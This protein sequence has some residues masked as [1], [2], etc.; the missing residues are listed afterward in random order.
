MTEEKEL[1]SPR[2]RLLSFID[3]PANLTRWTYV[4]PDELAAAMELEKKGRLSLK[5]DPCGAK[6][7]GGLSSGWLI[8][9]RNDEE[10]RGEMSNEESVS[11]ETTIEGELLTA[12][13]GHGRDTATIRWREGEREGKPTTASISTANLALFCQRV[14][15]ALS[16]HN[17]LA[18][19]GLTPSHKTQPPK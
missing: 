6:S 19:A 10:R 11:V 8:Q 2:V 12:W 13:I 5:I 17:P 4:H 3:D 1:E 16:F 15:D 14:L 7:F 9:P 18:L